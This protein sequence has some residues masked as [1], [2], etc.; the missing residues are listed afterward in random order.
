MQVILDTG[1]EEDRPSS[2]GSPWPGAT[3]FEA[4]F[5]E[6]TGLA[7]EETP[8]VR[9]EK[10][11]RISQQIAQIL[12]NTAPPSI[13]LTE[14]GGTL[15]TL[16]PIPGWGCVF[17]WAYKHRLIL[18]SWWPAGCEVGVKSAW[19]AEASKQ[20]ADLLA[21]N[22]MNH[23]GGAEAI[24][25]THGP[26]DRVNPLVTWPHEQLSMKNVE[27]PLR[28]AYRKGA[29]E[30]FKKAYENIT[31]NI[32][33]IRTGGYPSAEDV[34][35]RYP[36]DIVLEI[37]RS[38][39]DIFSEDIPQEDYDAIMALP[40]GEPGHVSPFTPFVLF[41]RLGDKML[42]AM[43]QNIFPYNMPPEILTA[44]DRFRS[45]AGALANIVDKAREKNT[46]I[47]NTAAGRK[48]ALTDP[49]NIMSDMFAK[50]MMTGKT[51]VLNLE[52]VD[53]L[54]Q[55]GAGKVILKMI[56]PGLKTMRLMAHYYA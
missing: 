54:V 3:H 29:K 31:E 20:I 49:D 15:R 27:S 51:D 50:Y 41:H 10:I 34:V 55:P 42:A 53:L 25:A 19:P 36:K 2:K 44:L 1:L 43:A 35:K 6:R 8:S 52:A 40:S 46:Y 21:A 7:S 17:L 4:R 48:H 38:M 13:P 23:P 12:N 11:R 18:R 32:H 22:Q 16:V 5:A 9:G 26:V 30:H 47:V 24:S 45:V 56:E 33:V 14:H 28:V 37:P 39:K